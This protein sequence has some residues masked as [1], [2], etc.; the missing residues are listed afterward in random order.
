MR[1]RR[2]LHLHCGGSIKSSFGLSVFWLASWTGRCPRLLVLLQRGSVPAILTFPPGKERESAHVLTHTARTH[3]V[4]PVCLCF[5]LWAFVPNQAP[6]I[7]GE[8]RLH[9]WGPLDCHMS[10][11]RPM[12]ITA[13]R[14]KAKESTTLELHSPK[15]YPVA[16]YIHT[17]T[18]A[19]GITACNHMNI[20]PLIE[21]FRKPVFFLFV[22]FSC[23]QLELKFTAG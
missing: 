21:Y 18:H 7:F 20:F 23:F 6:G 14:S 19:Q 16:Y 5:C 4:P 1:V 9:Q 12:P 15:C 22:F 8:S 3:T 17:Q 11:C 13:K 10:G 2:E